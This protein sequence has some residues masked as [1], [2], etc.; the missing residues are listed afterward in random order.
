[1]RVREVLM[2]LG[3]GV[4]VLSACDGSNRS[5]GGAIAEGA[6]PREAL[7]VGVS[8]DEADVRRVVA[9]KAEQL[10]RCYERMLKTDPNLAGEVV[11]AW[12]VKVNGYVTN[13]RTG[14]TRCAR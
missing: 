7:D 14:K 12:E 3:V 5:G 11:N 1:M 8:C 9:G 13:M 4:V 2:L 6:R 10:E